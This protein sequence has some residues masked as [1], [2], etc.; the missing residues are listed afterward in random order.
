MKYQITCPKCKHEFSYNEGEIEAEIRRN[1]VEIEDLKAKM[2]EFKL[3]SYSKKKEY[4]E[5]RKRW[6]LR[7]T[8]L[9]KRQTELKAI[10]KLMHDNYS[11]GILKSF[12][13]YVKEEIGLQRYLEL[14]EKAEKDA[15]SYN[16]ADMAKVQYTSN[17]KP[18]ITINK[19]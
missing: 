4:S 6:N 9:G 14:W 12:K 13:E 16:I 11:D 17:K 2:V 15:E 19:L 18:V 8:Q 3:W 10:R 5:T 7:L 1:A